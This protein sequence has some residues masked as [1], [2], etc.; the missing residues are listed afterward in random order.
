M[1]K[2]PFFL[3]RLPSSISVYDENNVE[4]DFKKIGVLMSGNGIEIMEKQVWI[5]ESRL[6]VRLMIGLVPPQVY[7][8]RVGRKKKE[9]KKKGRKTKE[10][11]MQL[12]H[13]N[14]CITNADAK[15]LPLE[16]IMPCIGFAGRWNCSSKIGSP[17]F[18]Y[19]PCRK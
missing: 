2:T 12:L 19:T 11:T 10:K 17:S 15:K 16:K 7:Q 8:Q 4:I 6:P 1:I 18:Q 9:E 5:G 13:F 3:S 14:L